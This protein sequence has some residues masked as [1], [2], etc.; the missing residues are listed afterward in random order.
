MSEIKKGDYISFISPFSFHNG[1]RVK[2]LVVG[3]HNGQVTVLYRR[4]NN[5]T[6]RIKLSLTDKSI[7]IREERS[8]K[9]V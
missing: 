6:D 9:S 4:S 3:V 7:E 5:G 1:K 8:C 2:G